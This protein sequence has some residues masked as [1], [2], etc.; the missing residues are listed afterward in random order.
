MN[1]AELR[2]ELQELGIDD[3]SWRVIALLPLVQ[4]A[5]ADGSV[6]RAESRAIEQIAAKHGLLVGDGPAILH[7]WLVHPPTE[8]YVARGRKV[9]VAL[10]RR[11]N[12]LDGEADPI[13]TLLEYCARIAASA[14]GLFGV[15]W[16][17]DERE[18][19]AIQEIAEG[20]SLPMDPAD[21]SDL[22]SLY[23]RSS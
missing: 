14:G 13:G 8:S 12:L 4:V 3:E 16:S 17:V 9:L 22:D 19:M 2:A 23:P 21:W 5:W 20:L 7:G 18:K 15:L 6:H 10:A 11:R 1:D